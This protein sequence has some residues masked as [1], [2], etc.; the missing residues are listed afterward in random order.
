MCDGISHIE[1]SAN[2]Y[3]LM[4]KLLMG[5]ISKVNKFAEYNFGDSTH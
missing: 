3:L 5:R 4:I 2:K 1:G